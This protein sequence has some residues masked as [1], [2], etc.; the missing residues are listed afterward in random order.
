MNKYL[1]IL[2]TFLVVGCGSSPMKYETTKMEINAAI[3]LAEEITWS[4]HRDWRPDGFSVNEKYISWEYGV[5]SSNKSWASGVGNT[6]F[7]VGSGTSTYRNSGNR[8]YYR[9]INRVQLYSWKRKFQQWYA[10]GIITKS[11]ENKFILRTKSLEDAELFTS[12]MT[13]IVDFYKTEEY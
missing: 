6:G 5:V 11:G 8:L 12:A 4:Q 9:Y 10:V 7:V 2:V 13:T 3:S 1:L